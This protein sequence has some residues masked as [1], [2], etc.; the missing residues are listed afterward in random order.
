MKS[1]NLNFLE[2]S[3]P[4]QACNG[5]ALFYFILLYFTLLYFTLLYFTL[6]YFTLLYMLLPFIRPSSGRGY[7][8]IKEN[9]RKN[10][11]VS[12]Y[13]Y[14]FSIWGRYIVV[15]IEAR[16]RLEGPGT[17]SRWGRDFPHPSRPAQVTTHPHL[18]PR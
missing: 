4:L 7:K 13:T 9:A 12:L 11:S 6:L 17:E 2:P 15:G 14:I 1:G 8:Y 3:G 5:A 18:A 16:Y 10:I